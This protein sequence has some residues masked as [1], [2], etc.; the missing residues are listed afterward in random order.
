[1]GIN[2]MLIEFYKVQQINLKKT[3][4]DLAKVKEH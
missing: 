2:N 4:G 3:M 1:M